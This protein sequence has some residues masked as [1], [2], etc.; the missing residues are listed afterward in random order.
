M[1]KKAG[2]EYRTIDD[3]AQ[4]LG[5]S[6]S[7]LR[8]YIRD[9]HFAKPPRQFFGSVGYAVFPDEYIREAQQRLREMRGLSDSD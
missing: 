9:G 6:I 2:R 1:K 8:R 5:V 7:T 4:E 3:A